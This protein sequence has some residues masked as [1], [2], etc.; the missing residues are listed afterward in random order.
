MSVG[1]SSHEDVEEGGGEGSPA[2]S[3]D[4][5]SHDADSSGGD[6]GDED[7]MADLAALLASNLA[8][9]TVAWMLCAS[10]GVVSGLTNPRKPDVLCR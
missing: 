9:I 7:D 5:D 3:S 2:P 10:V 4:A 1:A 6:S 8:V